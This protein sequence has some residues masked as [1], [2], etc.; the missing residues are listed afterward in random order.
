VVSWRV[1]GDQEADHVSV[2]T[3]RSKS[4]PPPEP[5]DRN[6]AIPPLKDGDR[7]TI[8]IRGRPATG[9]RKQEPIDVKPIA[10]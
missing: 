9:R 2:S 8:D 3:P 10:A 4:V 7:L 5:I 6:R 1:P